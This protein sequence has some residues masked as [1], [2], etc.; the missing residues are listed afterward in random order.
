MKILVINSGS[1]SLKYQLI[2]MSNEAV[3]AKGI[4]DRIGIDGTVKHNSLGKGE[5][6]INFPMK[7]HT[8]A[9]QKVIDTLT[10]GEYAVLKSIDEIS[11]VGHRIVHGGEYFTQ[12]VMVDEDVIEK[13]ESCN[14][15][16]PLHAYPNAAGIR[17]CRK[18]M[19]EIPQVV[20]FDT[21][22][23]Q[24]MPKYAYMYALPI[25]Y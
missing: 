11:A 10:K 5:F 8:E 16:A 23:H 21:A 9:S 25:E 14:L 19:P 17:A 1:S 18:I 15:L 7:D 4:C 20:V 22:F 24:T 2:D 6:K 13:I 12:S 3:I